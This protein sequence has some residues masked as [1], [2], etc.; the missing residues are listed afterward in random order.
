MRRL[1]LGLLGLAGAASA[2]PLSPAALD[3]V[4]VNPPPAARM[5]GGDYVDRFGRPV[6]LSPGGRPTLLLFVDYSCQH[7]CGPGLTLTTGALHDAGLIPARDYD[8]VVI[9]MDGDGPAKA[10]AFAAERLAS[11]PDEARAARFLSGSPATVAATEAALGYHAVYDPASDQWAH[12]AASFVFTPDGRLSRILPETAVVPVMMRGAVA[13]AARGDTLAGSSTLGR[14]VAVC[15]GFAAAHGLYG[16]V[17]ATLLRLA[18]L[19]TVAGLGLFVW[20]LA[21]RRAKAM[22]A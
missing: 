10:R 11:L 14:L 2:A 17:I 19:L 22:A 20:R 16:P 9:G 12:D 15:Y 3:A 13:A 7:L 21:R 4:G 1:L 18:G 5:P 6:R 8:L